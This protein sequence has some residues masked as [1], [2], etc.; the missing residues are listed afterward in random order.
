LTKVAIYAKNTKFLIDNQLKD[1]EDID[2]IKVAAQ[3]HIQGF[4]QLYLLSGREYI[5]NTSIPE[6]LTPILKTDI[7]IITGLVGIRY[8][9]TPC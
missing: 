8:V 4:T 5:N 3:L 7:A 6:Y 9:K 2:G 1:D